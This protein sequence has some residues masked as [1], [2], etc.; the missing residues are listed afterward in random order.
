MNPPQWRQRPVPAEER[1]EKGMHEADWSEN[2]LV[3]SIAI[4]PQNFLGVRSKLNHTETFIQSL[5]LNYKCEVK[6][7]QL[8]FVAFTTIR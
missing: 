1:C 8:A 3:R 4:L 7:F 2:E 5:H 6:S